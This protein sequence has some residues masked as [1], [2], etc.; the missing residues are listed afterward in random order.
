M[1]RQTR[2]RGGGGGGERRKKK[3]KSDAK[4]KNT[5]REFSLK[6]IKKASVKVK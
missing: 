1:E 4:L 5:A 2:G 3:R 6:G